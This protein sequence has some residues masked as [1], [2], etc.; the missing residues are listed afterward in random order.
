MRT[1]KAVKGQSGITYIEILIVVGI[2]SV[3][4]LVALPSIRLALQRQD[5]VELRR[6]LREIRTALDEYNKGADQ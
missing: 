4:S 5:E 6:A 2:V 1:V 3:L